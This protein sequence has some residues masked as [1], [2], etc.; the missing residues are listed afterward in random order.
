MAEGW[1]R[2]E[3]GAL[4]PS[5]LFPLGPERCFHSVQKCN[6]ASVQLFSDSERSEASAQL[7]KLC[8]VTKN[9][10]G[11][12]Q[13]AGNPGACPWRVVKGQKTP[14]LPE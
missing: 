10:G 8:L 13:Y 1:G 3:E 2:D 4:C 12:V 6:Q 14:A 5:V 11:S 7:G 9:T